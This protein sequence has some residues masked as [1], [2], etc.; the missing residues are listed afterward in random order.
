MRQRPWHPIIKLRCIKPKS[1]RQQHP[2]M[3][4]SES[5]V[6]TH[7]N[8]IVPVQVRERPSGPSSPNANGAAGKLVHRWMAHEALLTNAAAAS[9]Q[10]WGASQ[11]LG[12]YPP[13]K[14]SSPARL[15]CPQHTFMSTGGAH[16]AD[17]TCVL[18]KFGTQR[19]QCHPLNPDRAQLHTNLIGL[20]EGTNRA[21]G[22]RN[23]GQRGQAGQRSKRVQ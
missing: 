17:S 22:Q 10:A 6:P 2:Q 14:Q 18:Q 12:Q 15:A 5:P 23:L 8:G 1:P 11:P 4:E 13:A 20:G 3:R 19:S 16:R 21:C 9:H 7:R